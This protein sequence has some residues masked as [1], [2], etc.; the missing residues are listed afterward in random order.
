MEKP[1]KTIS[2]VF[3]LQSFLCSAGEAAS[4]CSVYVWYV[5]NAHGATKVSE[6]IVIKGKIEL[7][8]NYGT[9]KTRTFF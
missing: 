8:C 1:G 2:V 5:Q 7:L 4:M 6:E 3:F 9:Q